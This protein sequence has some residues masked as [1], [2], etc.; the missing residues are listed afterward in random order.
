[1]ECSSNDAEEVDFLSCSNKEI[2]SSKSLS[3]K[4][5]SAN[6]YLPDA[7]TFGCSLRVASSKYSKAS[8]VLLSLKS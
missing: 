5:D 4:Y 8:V 3:A 1:M 2:A 7:Y 6:Q